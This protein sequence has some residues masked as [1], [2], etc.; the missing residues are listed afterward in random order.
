MINKHTDLKTWKKQQ[1][2]Y[3]SQYLSCF[4]EGSREQVRLKK[5]LKELE[6]SI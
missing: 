3:F 4:D 1:L 2:E 5:A 6:L